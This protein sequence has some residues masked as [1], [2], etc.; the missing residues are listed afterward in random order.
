MKILSKTLIT[1]LALFVSSLSWAA[2]SW[3]AVMH[4]KLADYTS[5]SELHF[6]PYLHRDHLPYAPH[7]LAILV[8][9]RSRQMEIYARAKH[10]SWEYVTSYPILA[11]SG[12][13]GP[14]L[15]EGDRQVPEGIYHIV[16]LNPE[17]RFDLSMHVNYP[18]PF[19][20]QHARTDHRTRLGED[21]YIHGNRLSIGCIAIGNEA[22]QQLFPLV[23][24]TGIRH[25]EVVIAPDD[26]RKYRPVYGK[27]HPKW[28]PTLYK[29]IN[30]ELK[31]FPVRHYS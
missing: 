28:L 12:G 25:V 9:K 29:Q 3:S 15:H 19:D 2:E 30:H 18:N 6:L 11:A 23:Y 27:V 22:I 5:S 24:Y 4:D 14:K 17:S 10:S 26:F 13:Y 7:E 31:Q 20:K 21:I 8:F 1:L 16:G